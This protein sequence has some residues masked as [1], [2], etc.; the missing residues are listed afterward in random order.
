MES[1][2]IDLIATAIAQLGIGGIFAWL[3]IRKDREKDELSKRKDQE[4]SDLVT[5]LITSYNENTKVQEGVK[6]SIEANT[7][8]I[9]DHK[10]LTEKIYEELIK[11]GNH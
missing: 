9:R 1:I 10:T 6:S 4:K 2:G 7:Q 11:N 8:A 3:F 5:Q